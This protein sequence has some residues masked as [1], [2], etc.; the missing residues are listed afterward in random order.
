MVPMKTRKYLY[1][2][3]RHGIK[4]DRKVNEFKTYS[5]FLKNC[6]LLWGSQFQDKIQY[7]YLYGTLEG[8]FPYRYLSEKKL[9]QGN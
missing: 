2:R 6:V 4:L 7:S 9:K 8:T 5:I 3:T 1:R